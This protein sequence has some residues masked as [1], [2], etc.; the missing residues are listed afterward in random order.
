MTSVVIDTN[1]LVSALLKADGSEAAVLFHVADKELRWCIL[2]AILAECR[3]VL[4]RPKFA[5]IPESYIA[6]LLRLAGEADLVRPSFTLSESVHEPD[7]RFLECAE[8]AGANYLVTGNR[9]HYPSRWK[10]TEIVNARE[11][12]NTISRVCD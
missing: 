4:H 12:L 6:E 3:A 10:I 2:P 8:A 11:L 9:R 1:V 7:N 5:R